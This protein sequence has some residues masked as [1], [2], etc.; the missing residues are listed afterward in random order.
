MTAACDWCGAR[1]AELH[2]L[3]GRLCPGGP[4]LDPTL[5]GP[6]CPRHHAADHAL[7]RRLGL[8]WPEPGA[9]LLT[10]RLLRFGV[11]LGRAADLG[12]PHVLAPVA[13]GG[14]HALVIEVAQRL[15][16]GQ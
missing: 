12:R 8:D 13:A 16:A 6:R 10:Y 2:H 4:Y 3:T 1:R 7:L 14:A 9:D 11:P 15:G 5:T